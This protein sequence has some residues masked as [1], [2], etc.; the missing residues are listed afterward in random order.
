[1]AHL[2]LAINIISMY[3]SAPFTVQN[4]KKFLELIQNYEDAQFLGPKW[5]ICPQQILFW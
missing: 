5:P 1:M 4:L 2:S 3:L